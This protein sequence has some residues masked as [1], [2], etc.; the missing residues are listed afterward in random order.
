MTPGTRTPQRFSGLCLAALLGSL[1]GAAARADTDVVVVSNGDMLTGEVKSLDRG[2]LRFKTD[3]TDTIEIQWSYVAALSSEQNF[4]ITLDDDRQLFG[5]LGE[6][7][8]DAMLLLVTPIGPLSLPLLSV[9]RMTPI[10]G[11]LIDRID[12]SVNLGYNFTKASN[13]NQGTLGYDFSY[14]SEQRLLSLGLDGTRSSSTDEPVSI[15]TSTALTYRRFIGERL[16][17]P[18]GFGVIERNDELGL[19][20]RI[21]GGGGMSR[22]LTDTNTRRISFM[23]GIVLTEED[24][25]EALDKDQSVE[26][27]IGITLDWFRYDDPELDVSLDFTVYER[28]SDSGRT[29]G[30]LDFD[31]R[32]EL[33]SDFFLGFTTYYSFNS[34][35]TGEAASDDYGVFTTVGWSF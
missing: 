32:W 16:W 18:V 15:R 23:G 29:R 8:Q 35:P 7:D 21:T 5:T 4:Q 19:D 12:M 1:F 28:L 9:V 13:V 24:E 33:V 22:W 20:R 2:L 3:A 10:E 17:D 34:R 14:R 25:R 26:A 11:R 27:A 31:M 6:S 30:T